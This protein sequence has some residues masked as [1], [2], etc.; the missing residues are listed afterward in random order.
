ML[1]LIGD[2]VGWLIVTGIAIVTGWTARRVVRSVNRAPAPHA[3]IRVHEAGTVAIAVRGVIAGPAAA[4]G[5]LSGAPCALA[6]TSV[7]ATDHPQHANWPRPLWQ[8]TSTGDLQVR[9]DQEIRTSPKQVTRRPGT[10]AVGAGQI[11]V[12]T[13]VGHAARF[14]VDVATLDRLSA[15]G[16]PP[17]L[18]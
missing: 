3:L 10:L 4:R 13:P 15:V 16:L 6:T 7:T 5:A 18:R 12:D 8:W 14:P 2:V 17:A 11:V 1:G 9:Y